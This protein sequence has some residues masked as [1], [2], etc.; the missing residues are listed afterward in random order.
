VDVYSLEG[1]LEDEA[2]PLSVPGTF[3]SWRQI[4]PPAWAATASLRP[5]DDPSLDEALARVD[6]KRH[7]GREPSREDPAIA[8]VWLKVPFAQKDKAKKLG[9]KWSAADKAWWLLETNTAAVDEARRLGFLD[10]ADT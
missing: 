2:S 6:K 4:E 10:K 8:R 9:A 5:L 7:R 3:T 1:V